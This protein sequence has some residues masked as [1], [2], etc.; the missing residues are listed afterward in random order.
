MGGVAVAMLTPALGEHVL[1]LRLQHRK[2]PD[3]LEVS[4]ETGFS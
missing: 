4:R 3:L 2:P 1:F